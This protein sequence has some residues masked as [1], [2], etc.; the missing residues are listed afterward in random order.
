[1]SPNLWIDPAYGDRL[2]ADA[3]M[4][5]RYFQEPLS[6]CI[7]AVGDNDEIS[8]RVL[9]ENHYQVLGIDLREHCY[10]SV[11]YFRLKADVSYLI[12][13]K[14]LPEV[15][16]IYS[17][18]A[19]EHF[20][21][22]TYPDPVWPDPVL[23]ADLDAKVLMQFWH[24]LKPNGTIYLTVPYGEKY[25]VHGTDWRVYNQ[26]ELKKR[27]IQDYQVEEKV[28]FKSAHAACP[29]NGESI[30]LVTEEDANQYSGEPPHVTC[31]LKLR[32]VV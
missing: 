17:L 9:A 32:K 3:Q 7:L 2:C 23:D 8:A 25:I 4:F 1:M 11:K 6:A 13:T 21:L 10:P 27:L 16:C 31:L 18:S 28:F 22:G 5:L 15:D 24:I 26:K 19:I 20:G 30:P 29:D 14:T 12:L